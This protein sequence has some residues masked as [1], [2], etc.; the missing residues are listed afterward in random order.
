MNLDGAVNFFDISPFIQVLASNSFRAE[1][2]I[3]K[4]GAVNFFDISNFITLLSG[5]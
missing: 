1:A 4:D 3:N 2:D 5:S